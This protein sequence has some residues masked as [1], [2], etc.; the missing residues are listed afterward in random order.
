MVSW[1]S[2]QRLIRRLD[3][4]RFRIAPLHDKKR[5]SDL[6]S[7]LELNNMSVLLLPSTD[8]TTRGKERSRDLLTVHQAIV[9]G[10]EMHRDTIR[11]TINHLQLSALY[12]GS[13][14]VFNIHIRPSRSSIQFPTSPTSSRIHFCRNLIFN[15][16]TSSCDL[17]LEDTFVLYY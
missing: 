4:A 8:R 5:L 14:L 2:R 16:F 3:L 12:L 13:P 1:T 15:E 9:Y 10:P 17:E 7:S 6:L 11:D